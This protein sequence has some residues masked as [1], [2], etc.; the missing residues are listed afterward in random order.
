MEVSVCWSA[1]RKL[2]VKASW[3]LTLT[4][5]TRDF[6]SFKK[7]LR[8]AELL[9]FS[10]YFTYAEWAGYTPIYEPLPRPFRAASHHSK[11]LALLPGPPKTLRQSRSVSFRKLM[12][13]NKTNRWG[14]GAKGSGSRHNW[15]FV[16]RERTPRQKLTSVACSP[17]VLETVFAAKVVCSICYM[18]WRPHFFRRS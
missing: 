5:D 8:V 13:R 18:A 12:S 11:P 16:K 9:E 2:I 14:F 17:D 6:V 4:K 7:T 15:R 3:S 10:E 1:F